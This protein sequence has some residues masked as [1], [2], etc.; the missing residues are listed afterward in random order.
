MHGGALQEQS[1]FRLRTRVQF[2][3][4]RCMA[5]VATRPTVTET[6]KLKDRLVHLGVEILRGATVADPFDA[7][8]GAVN[9]LEFAHVSR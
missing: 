6:R 1:Q 2:A 7:P 4:I 9:S 3:S 5:Q 8:Q